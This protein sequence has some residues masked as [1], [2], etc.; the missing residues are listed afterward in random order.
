MSLLQLAQLQKIEV[1]RHK[2]IWHAVQDFAN[3][4]EKRG[5]V[6]AYSPERRPWGRINTHCNHLKICLKQIFRPTYA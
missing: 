5:Q 1:K 2:L 4:G 3:S 6:G